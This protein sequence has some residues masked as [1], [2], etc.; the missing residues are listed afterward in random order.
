V[1]NREKPGTEGRLPF[2][3]GGRDDVQVEKREIS[4][5]LVRGRSPLE[6]RTSSVAKSKYRG[7]VE[8]GYA[9]PERIQGDTRKE[10]KMLSEPR[11]SWP[12]WVPEG[13]FRPPEKGGK[14]KTDCL[15][16]QSAIKKESTRRWAPGEKGGATSQQRREGGKERK[17]EKNRQPS[18]FIKGGGGGNRSDAEVEERAIVSLW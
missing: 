2:Q 13:T 7:G 14:K 6:K 9:S 1:G 3:K 4:K 8:T 11:K 10:G 15:S 16:L 18:C 17:R 5:I 12:C